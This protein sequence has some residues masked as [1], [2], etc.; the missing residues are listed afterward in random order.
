M[1]HLNEKNEITEKV[2]HLLITTKC[3]RDCKYCCNKQYN[4]DE[5]PV[6]TREE[7]LKAETLCLTGGEPF[8]FTKPNQLAR[9]YKTKYPNIQKVFVYTSAKELAEYIE[10]SGEL[11]YIN[12]LTISIKDKADLEAFEKIKNNRCV[13]G[14][15]PQRRKKNRIYVYNNIY[16]DDPTNYRIYLREWQPD[17]VPAKDSIFRRAMKMY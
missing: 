11:S 14:N 13:T 2:I 10:E 5:I 15:L 7:L 6:V 9:T 8:S 16:V 17:F 12:G 1:A 4:I 3:N